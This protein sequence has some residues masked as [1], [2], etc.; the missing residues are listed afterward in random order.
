MLVGAKPPVS[1][2]AYPGKPSWCAP[3]GC[4]F[5]HLAQPH[6]DGA[7]ALQDLAAALDA[8]AEPK[9][10]TPLALRPCRRTGR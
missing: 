8:P 5:A 2:F 9:A 6:E 7:L 3:E 1:F 10:R 4:V